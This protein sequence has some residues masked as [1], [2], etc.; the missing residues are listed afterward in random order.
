MTDRADRHELDDE[1]REALLATRTIATIL[2]NDPGPI[3]DA[4]RAAEAM[5]AALADRYPNRI[6][7]L[8]ALAALARATRTAR[9]ELLDDVLA[10]RFRWKW[11]PEAPGRPAGFSCLGWQSY[12]L[13]HLT[14][15]SGLSRTTIRAHAERLLRETLAAAEA[16]RTEES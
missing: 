12:E 16:A 3:G 15:A 6:V 13:D 14:D 10:G 2:G 4:A 8:I 7:R 5:V 11:Y 9:D 1:E